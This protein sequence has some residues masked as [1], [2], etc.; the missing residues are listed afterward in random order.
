M[1]M[2][3]ECITVR[4]SPHRGPATAIPTSALAAPRRAIRQPGGT[5]RAGGS[6]R[7]DDLHA[8]ET[9]ESRRLRVDLVGV[10]KHE[11]GEQRKHDAERE[12]VW[13]VEYDIAHGIGPRRAAR[14]SST[15]N[16]SA[17]R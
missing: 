12:Q 10:T 8:S 17:A 15:T 14:S 13:I 11:H 6:S 1:S 3:F 5:E 9:L 16:A 7:V 4:S 2:P